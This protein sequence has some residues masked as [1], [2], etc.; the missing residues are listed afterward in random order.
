MW[1][2]AQYMLIFFLVH[3]FFLVRWHFNFVTLLELGV[4][5]S[6]VTHW[7]LSN[8]VNFSI[9]F[10]SYL[11]FIYMYLWFN[12]ISEY[13]FCGADVV[14][15]CY[16]FCYNEV[17][18]LSLKS[19]TLWYIVYEIKTVQHIILKNEAP[20]SLFFFLF[21]FFFSFYSHEFS[22]F[23]YIFSPNEHCLC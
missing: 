1:S 12:V 19:F 20:D 16:V 14:F 22:A 6:S 15:K 2:T 10:Y 18:I 13:H 21:Y 3:F 7:I 9:F 5:N 11:V 17:L 23:I 8:F 4:L